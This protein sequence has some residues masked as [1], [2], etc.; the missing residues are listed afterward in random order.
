MDSSCT[1]FFASTAVRM[2]T[3]L[4]SCLTRPKW[5]LRDRQL[6]AP[7]RFEED[8]NKQRAISF[9]ATTDAVSS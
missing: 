1:F 7:L 2:R 8:D 3:A 4:P 5:S 9:V 6:E